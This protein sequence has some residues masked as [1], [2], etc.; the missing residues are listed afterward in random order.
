M[1]AKEI[2]HKKN[3]SVDLLSLQEKSKSVIVVAWKW[4]VVAIGFFLFTLLLMKLLPSYLVDNKNLYLGIILVTG[5]L[6]SIFSFIKFWKNSF[7]KQVFY[8][9][10]A[11]VPIIE[12]SVG[13]PSKE[14]FSKFISGVELQ[15]ESF[16]K[17]IKIAED[18]MLIGEMK[19]LRRLSD[20]GVISKKMYE[21]AKEKLFSGFDS[22]AI[23]SDA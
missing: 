23:N 9:K 15:I 2:E 6:G 21:A 8:S 4:L 10:S 5:L 1:Q 17:S 19:M 16:S 18:K 11:H 20:D 12:L 7:K 22:K 3:Y 13:K 14:I